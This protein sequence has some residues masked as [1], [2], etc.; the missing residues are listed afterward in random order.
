MQVSQTCGAELVPFV[1]TSVGPTLGIQQQTP[2]RCCRNS[3][4]H[5]SMLPVQ[6]ECAAASLTA[7]E[8]A[9]CWVQA[10]VSAIAAGDQKQL[11]AALLGV[12]TAQQL[13]AR[14]SNG[15]MEMS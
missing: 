15:H 4:C 10:L 8:Q 2:V 9:S 3:S 6:H 11:K 12:V 13:P 1:Q 7:C 14:L 5:A